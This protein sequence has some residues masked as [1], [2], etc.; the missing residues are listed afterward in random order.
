MEEGDCAITSWHIPHCATRNE[1]GTESRKNII[2]RIRN[3]SRQ[4]NHVITGGGGPAGG[5]FDRGVRGEYLTAP[6]VVDPWE[7]SKHAICNMW[8]EWEGM[9][10]FVAEKERQAQQA[11][12]ATARL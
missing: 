1:S 2:F 7:R 8:H 3:K 10:E 6:Q 12:A 9:A 5:W 11:E 4:P